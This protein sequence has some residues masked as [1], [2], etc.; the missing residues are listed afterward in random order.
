MLF[1]AQTL[2]IRIVSLTLYNKY[3]VISSSFQ[4]KEFVYRGQ[5]LERI[6]NFQKRLKEEFDKATFMSGGTLLDDT[7]K[8]GPGQCIL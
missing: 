6:A 1:H 8:N 2:H 5:V 4:N 3:S 7:V